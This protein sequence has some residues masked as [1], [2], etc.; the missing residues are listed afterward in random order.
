MTF[1]DSLN[2]T[3]L[4][5][6]KL[7]IIPDSGSGGFDSEFEISPKDFLRYSKEDLN[8]GNDRGIINALSNAKRAI[9]CLIDD[10]LSYYGVD[11][12]NISKSFEPFVNYFEFKDDIPYKLKIIQSLNLA[13]GFIIAKYRNLRNKLEHLYK[14][15]SYD[16]VKEAIDIAELFIRSIEGHF[17]S[18]LDSFIITDGQ[19]F[20]SD[21]DF[22]TGYNFFFQRKQKSICLNEILSGKRANEVLISINDPLY[23]G[24]IRLMNSTND[25]FELTESFKIISTLINHPI[26]T[27]HINVE[28]R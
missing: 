4:D 7:I 18:N 26:P 16:E 22:K 19:N 24:F 10:I 5:L 2:K 8:S 27:K 9:D 23:W 25:E 14:I 11:Y 21:F 12:L 6:T 3:K 17:G 1:K 28:L 13:P 15:P 20:I